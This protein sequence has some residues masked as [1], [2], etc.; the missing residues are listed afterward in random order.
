MMWGNL[1]SGILGSSYNDFQG[2]GTT[3]W[4]DVEYLWRQHA[5]FSNPYADAFI[6]FGTGVSWHTGT[7]SPGGSEVDFRSVFCHELGHSLGFIDTYNPVT[8]RWTSLGLTEWDKLLRDAATDGNQ[9]NVNGRGT[10]GNFNQTANPVYLDG[11]NAKAANGGN[12]VAIY[13]PSPFV[14]QD[15]FGK[16]G[17]I[18]PR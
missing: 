16:A 5:S 15:G 12:R 3:A 7:S 13:A 8:D 10:P 14:R 9:P 6:Q 11:A 18:R 2:N 17:F 1:G 4:T